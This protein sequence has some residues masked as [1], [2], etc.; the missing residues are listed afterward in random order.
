[1]RGK[2]KRQEEYEEKIKRAMVILTQ[3]SEDVATP[4]NIR[5]AAREAINALESRNLTF[6]V[7]AANAISILDEISQDP[8]MPAHTRVNLWSAISIIEAIRDV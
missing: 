4:R 8:N 6:A 1:M 5:R 2:K 3:V 7:R